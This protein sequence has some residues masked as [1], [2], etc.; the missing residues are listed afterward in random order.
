MVIGST[1]SLG[2][3]V[4][5]RGRNLPQDVRA[6][7]TRL[8]DLLPL[9]RRRLVVSG[10]VDRSTVNLILEFQAVVLLMSRPSG[11]ITPMGDTL[12]AM[13]DP[14]SA[15]RWSSTAAAARYVPQQ[16]SDGPRRAITEM[17]R[18]ANADVGRIS[19]LDDFFSVRETLDTMST[20]LSGASALHYATEFSA[21]L[22]EL[23]QI[24]L[25]NAQIRVVMLRAV[26]DADQ[27]DL[28]LFLVRENPGILGRAAQTMSR[29]SSALN[30]VSFLLSAYKVAG[31]MRNGVSGVAP[32]LAEIYATVMGTAVPWAG[33]VDGIQ[34]LLGLIDPTLQG[35]PTVRTVFGVLNAVNPIGL[36]RVGVDAI[37]SLIIAALRCLSE[38]RCTATDLEDFTTRTRG[39][40]MRV[41]VEWGESLGNAMGD[42]WGQAFYE[43]FLR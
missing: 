36:G 6:V 42:R 14:A 24:G 35:S 9:P 31:F 23:R 27:M 18:A 41:F 39:T 28:L 12:A 21:V 29:A 17:R 16:E 10:V 7:Q 22:V 15:R 34:G 32:S 33:A 30:A 5:Q 3:S 4:G 40:P 26:R 43:R 13:N 11:R 20:W 38:G 8:N 2:G 19:A 1:I 25:D 37:V